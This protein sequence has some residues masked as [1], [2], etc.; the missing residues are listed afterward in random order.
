MCNCFGKLLHVH[1]KN[2]EHGIWHDVDS[3]YDYA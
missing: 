3:A 1:S 2:V